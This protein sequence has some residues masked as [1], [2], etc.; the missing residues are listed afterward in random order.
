[1]KSQS[2]VFAQSDLPRTQ[3]AHK[4]APGKWEP[5]LPKD[6][7]NTVINIYR[8]HSTAE[9]AVE[10]L[11]KANYDVTNLAIVSREYLDGY[12]A[13]G[14]GMKFWTW[15]G[16]LWGGL[17]GL[18]VSVGLL[19]VPGVR[20]LL[21]GVPFLNVIL[22]VIQGAVVGG[23]LS[24]L[25]AGLIPR[26][27]LFVLGIPSANLLKYETVLQAGKCLLIIHGTE[28][29]AAEARKMVSA[30]TAPR[31]SPPKPERKHHDE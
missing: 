12:R 20:P 18:L 24:A 23:G 26:A 25:V 19:W 8:S 4:P 6:Q 3:S 14:E 30:N 22:C 17:A 5:K 31:S 9:A 16:I 27:T 28:E 29:A 2:S 1:M 10:E 13:G 7:R 15:R 21:V 11:Q